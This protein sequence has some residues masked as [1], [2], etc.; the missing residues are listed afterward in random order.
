[1]VIEAQNE[2]Y[3][4]RKKILINKINQK[5]LNEKSDIEDK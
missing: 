1:M 5:L 3:I 4:R 2:K